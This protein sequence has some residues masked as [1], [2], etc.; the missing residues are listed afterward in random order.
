MA[1]KMEKWRGR[2]EQGRRIIDGKAVVGWHVA[3]GLCEAADF[4]N[5]HTS[6]STIVAAN[7]RRKGWSGFGRTIMCPACTAKKPVPSRAAEPEGAMPPQQKS[8]QPAPEQAKALINAAKVAQH[9]EVYWQ[10]QQGRYDDGWSDERIGRDLG[11]ISPEFVRSIREGLGK[12][13]KRHPDI[14]RAEEILE[15][16]RAEWI[17]RVSDLEAKCEEYSKEFLD[18]IGAARALIAKADTQMTGGGK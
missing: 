18:A 12:V 17:G 16:A 14:L 6:D 10:D 7:L 5:H 3:C 13:P 2:L 8:P 11:G 4:S 15:K 1:A 9:L